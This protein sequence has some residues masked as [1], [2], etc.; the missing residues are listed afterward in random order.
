MR[1]AGDSTTVGDRNMGA[2]CDFRAASQVESIT[3]LGPNFTVCRVIASSIKQ[4]LYINVLS[5]SF[6]VKILTALSSRLHRTS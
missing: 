3:S 1:D 4:T 5:V 2:D 6:Q